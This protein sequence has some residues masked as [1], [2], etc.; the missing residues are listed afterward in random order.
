MAEETCGALLE[1]SRRVKEIPCAKAVD[2]LLE[3]GYPT[4]QAAWDACQNVEWME[5]LMQFMI[6]G[7]E[8]GR[9]NLMVQTARR[10]YNEAV[11]P[12]RRAYFEA[13]CTA[14]ARYTYEA[15]MSVIMHAVMP[16]LPPEVPK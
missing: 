6:S 15:A 5:W 3:G 12:A 4:L 14:T 8:C 13:K 2:W 11:I 9:H 1:L 7:P 10:A 16:V